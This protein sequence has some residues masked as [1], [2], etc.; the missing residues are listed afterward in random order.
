MEERGITEEVL[1]LVMQ[2][3]RI[4]DEQNR[5]VLEAI[6]KVRYDP[7]T[8]TLTMRLS[9]QKV[10]EGDEAHPGV[11]LDYDKEGNASGIEILQASKSGAMPQSIEY[12]YG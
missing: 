9:D 12:T 3:H 5:Q 4:Q 1:D 8:D 2:Y 7:E 6:M 10:M 11:I